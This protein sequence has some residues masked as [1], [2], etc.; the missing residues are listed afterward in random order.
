MRK[1]AVILLMTFALS[2]HAAD[3]ERSAKVLKLLDVQGVQATFEDQMRVREEYRKRSVQVMVDE[4]L[5]RL[6]PN[7]VF[8]KKFNA[9]A[10][11]LFEALQPPWASQEVVDIWAGIYGSKYT[12][13]ELDLLLAF[14]SSPVAQKEVNAGRE[15]LMEFSQYLQMQYRPVEQKAVQQYVARMQLLG[16]ECR[17]KK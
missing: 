1:L 7:A 13:E 16:K 11:E 15:S 4:T 10:M 3:P 12:E 14:Y 9:A 5:K 2:A 6:K 8:R 17:C